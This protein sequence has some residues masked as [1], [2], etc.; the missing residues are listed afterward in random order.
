[1]YVVFDLDNAQVSIAQAVANAS[2]DASTSGSGSNI[3]V[4]QAGPNGVE[5]AVGSANGGVTTAPPNSFTIAPEASATISLSDQ[6]ISPAVGV[7][8][9]L[10]AIPEQGQANVNPSTGATATPASGSDSGSGSSSGG[11]SSTSSPHKAAAT[12]VS[13]PSFSWNVLAV[14]SVWFGMAA[15]GAGLV[16]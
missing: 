5:A 11:S 15:I 14:V 16:L 13:I 7:A 4:V 1:M 12:T 2:T 3:K 9:G 10:A 6:T 8:V